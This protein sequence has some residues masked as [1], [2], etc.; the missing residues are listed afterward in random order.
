MSV[1]Q[2]LVELETNNRPGALCLIVRSKGSTPRRSGSKMLVYPNGSIVGTVGGGELENRVVSEALAAIK[3]GRPRFLEYQMSDP[4]RGDPGICGGQVEVFV[5]PVQ[6]K[7]KVVIIGAGHVGKAVAHLAHW[8][9]YWVIVNDDRPALCSPEMIPD[10]DDYIV[11]TMAELSNQLE[12]GPNTYVILATRGSEVDINGLPALLDQPAAYIGVIGSQRRWAMTRKQLINNGITAEKIEKVRSPI[13]L[14]L[15]AE[16]PEEIAVSIM[17]E[18]IMLREG[19]DGKV[20][21][22]QKGSAQI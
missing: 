3:D 10:A 16:T 22:A 14:E 12:I 9:G 17:A 5:D 6:V 4:E 13:G 1:F 2:A 21:S 19:G 20:M 7:P 15:N 11:S 18:I 8:L